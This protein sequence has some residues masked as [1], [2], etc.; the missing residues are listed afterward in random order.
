LDPGLV[1]LVFIARVLLIS[2]LP[3]LLVAGLP[4]VSLLAL[5]LFLPLNSRLDTG[6]ISRVFGIHPPSW[7]SSLAAVLGGMQEKHV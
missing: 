3:L 4:L 5:N 7:Q 1:S 6:K 2:Y